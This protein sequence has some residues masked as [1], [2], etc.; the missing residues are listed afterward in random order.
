MYNFILV[1]FT[2]SLADKSLKIVHFGKKSK[3]DN[4]VTKVDIYYL[5]TIL[6]PL[7]RSPDEIT[8]MI[9]RNVSATHNPLSNSTKQVK[10]LK[11]KSDIEHNVNITHRLIQNVSF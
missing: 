6:A 11:N 3:I 5:L 8:W 7:I 2:C 10:T 4:T 1:N 9:P